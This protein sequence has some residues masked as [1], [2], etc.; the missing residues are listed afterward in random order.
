MTKKKDLL[1]L[2][3]LKQKDVYSLSL[4]LLYNLTAIPKYSLIGELPYLLEEDDLLKLCKYLGGKTITIPTVDELMKTMRTLLLYQAY[5]IEGKPW[6]QALK[7]SGFDTSEGRA[8]D[9]ALF[10]FENILQK[11]DVQTR[12]DYDK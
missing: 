7:E 2:D 6:A 5:T 10:A 3:D 1:D 4:F 9:R 11:Y 12:R 8:A